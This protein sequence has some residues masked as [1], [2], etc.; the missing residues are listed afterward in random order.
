MQGGGSLMTIL[1]SLCTRKGF[2]VSEGRILRI[3]LKN[4]QKPQ[5][6]KY[7]ATE[8]T[9]SLSSFY[10]IYSGRYFGVIGGGSGRKCPVTV[11]YLA[12]DQFNIGDP[13]EDALVF[14]PEGQIFKSE[15]LGASKHGR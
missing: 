8:T 13:K 9:D 2:T 1:T 3:K 6:K 10:I 11:G 15:S 7:A 5:N 14:C 4:L 12:A